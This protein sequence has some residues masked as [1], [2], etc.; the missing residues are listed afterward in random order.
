MIAKCINNIGTIKLKL[1][2]EYETNRVYKWLGDEWIDIMDES[3][4]YGSYLAARFDIM[5]GE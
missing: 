2:K 1:N 3:G 4:D 5:E